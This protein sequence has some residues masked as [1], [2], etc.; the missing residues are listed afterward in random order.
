MATPSQE[1]TGAV[2]G[3]RRRSAEV[4]RPRLRCCE[5]GVPGP[6]GRAVPAT[7]SVPARPRLPWSRVNTVWA[8]SGQ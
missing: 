8:T 7:I 4:T 2:L 6:T 1:D 5:C 3:D